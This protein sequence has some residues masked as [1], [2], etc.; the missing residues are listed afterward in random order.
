MLLEQ[1]STMCSIFLPKL[2]VLVSMEVSSLFQGRHNLLYP[3]GTELTIGHRE[4]TAEF[5]QLFEVDLFLF[6]AWHTGLVTANPALDRDGSGYSRF[7]WCRNVLPPLHFRAFGNDGFYHALVGCVRHLG[8]ENNVVV[9]HLVIRVVRNYFWLHLDVHD[10]TLMPQILIH[11]K[12]IIVP[13]SIHRFSILFI[14]V[15]LTLGLHEV[16]A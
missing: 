11:H 7:G 12:R 3:L 9:T 15:M 14:F 5:S 13:K 16:L 1:S 8:V 2:I 10:L 6:A 4:H